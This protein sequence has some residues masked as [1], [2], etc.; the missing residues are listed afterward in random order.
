MVKVCIFCYYNLVCNPTLP[1][2]CPDYTYCE[3]NAVPGIPCDSKRVTLFNTVGA[4]A[5]A[6]RCRGHDV[7]CVGIRTF[8]F[9]DLVEYV[10]ANILQLNIDLCIWWDYSYLSPANT[11]I[12]MSLFKECTAH[13]VYNFDPTRGRYL[14]DSGYK[15]LYNIAMVTDTDQPSYNAIVQCNGMPVPTCPNTFRPYWGCALEKKYSV[16]F[17][18][19]NLYTGNTNC[20]NRLEVCKSLCREFKGA[21]ALYCP[22][23]VADVCECEESYKGYVSYVDMPSIINSTAVCLCLHCD[24]TVRGYMND[25]LC[26]LLMCGANILVDRVTGLDHL[27]PYVTFID[28]VTSIVSQVKRLLDEPEST[29][30]TRQALARKYALEH[31]SADAWARRVEDGYSRYQ[32]TLPTA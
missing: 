7:I 26:H 24:N 8:A 22:A 19:T 10:R 5:A 17:A 31:L 4:A 28:S 21:F 11:K 29:R 15:A 6:L 16:M 23:S 13:A 32:K 20:Y 2:L 12:I 25:R 18:F 9:D 30:K 27:E 14:L 3:V 1:L